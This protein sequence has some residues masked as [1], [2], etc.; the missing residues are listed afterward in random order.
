MKTISLIRLVL[1]LLCLSLTGAIIT[2]AKAQNNNQ[3][4]I[5]KNLDVTPFHD[6]KIEGKFKVELR[7]G[8]THSV[9]VR[10]TPKQLNKLRVTQKEASIEI[11]GPKGFT[12]PSLQIYITTPNI[13]QLEL[14]GAIRVNCDGQTYT[15]ATFGIDLEGVSSIKGLVVNSSQIKASA[16]GVSKIEGAFEGT[17]ISINIEGVSNG[18]INVTNCQMVDC[19][20][21]GKSTGIIRGTTNQLR[22]Q[23]EGV[24]KVKL[25][26]LQSNIAHLDIEGIC[27]GTI[28]APRELSYNVEGMS[29]LTIY[30]KVGKLTNTDVSEKSKVIYR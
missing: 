7:K 24:S 2:N 14:S 8:S 17:N 21:S 12:D 29:K 4:S 13:E 15:P 28:S 3:T 16:E 1:T 20:V 30:G 18:N 25:D 5:T 27:S 23:C 10:A 6:I 9:K 11:E 22:V 19:V 26:N